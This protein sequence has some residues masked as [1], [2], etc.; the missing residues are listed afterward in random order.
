VKKLF[1]ILLLSTRAY[2]TDPTLIFATG[3]ERVSPTPSQYTYQTGN[4]N[5]TEGEGF[6]YHQ[7]GTYSGANTPLS[8]NACAKFF[9]NQSIDCGSFVQQN[10]AIDFGSF[11]HAKLYGPIYGNVHCKF[12]DN[13]SQSV[14]FF[15]LSNP[16]PFTHAV[17]L[18]WTSGNKIALVINGSTV[19]TTTNSVSAGFHLVEVFS[20]WGTSS[21][22]TTVKVAGE[23]L[24]SNASIGTD[25]IAV[26]MVGM[27]DHIGTTVHNCEIDMDDLIL[28]TGAEPDTSVKV[29]RSVAVSDNAINHWTRSDGTTSTLYAQFTTPPLNTIKNVNAGG[30]DNYDVNVQDYVTAGLN[31]A[32]QHVYAVQAIARTGE[33]AHSTAIQGSVQILS[34][35]ASSAT[36]FNFGLNQGAWVSESYG[37]VCGCITPACTDNFWYSFPTPFVYY[38]ASP[39]VV[40]GTQPVVRVTKV[41]ATS[42]RV[43]VDYVDLNFLVAAGATTNTSVKVYNNME[44]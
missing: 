36:T 24:T 34:N 13:N 23:T 28:A 32:T 44:R 19:A 6:D 8:G 37:A 2:A 22:T 17:E 29:L 15:R 9:S 3:W 16:F 25:S 31:T 43:D 40:T 10:E 4:G 42:A 38:G 30:N 18:Q 35:P 33:F 5:S 27:L 11:I 21:V 1:L 14:R 12:V 39:T 41:S 20:T 7:Q 26:L